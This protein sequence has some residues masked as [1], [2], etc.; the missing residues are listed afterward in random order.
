MAQ[1]SNLPPAMGVQSLN[2]W[3]A[4]E[5][6]SLKPP[7]LAVFLLTLKMSGKY[8]CFDFYAVSFCVVGFKGQLYSIW[9][10]HLHPK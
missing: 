6:K 10:P 2:H 4:S 1:G 9:K 3:R 5:G 7:L 8:V